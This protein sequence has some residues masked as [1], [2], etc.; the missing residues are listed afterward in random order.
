MLPE[1]TLMKKNQLLLSVLLFSVLSVLYSCEKNS[2]ED[3]PTTADRE[4]FL[5]TW[6]G[7]S[8]GTVNGQLNWNMVITASNSAPDQILMDNFDGVGN[9]VKIIASVSGNSITIPGAP[10]NVISAT[11]DTITGSGSY[12]SNN[13]LSFNFTV[14]DGQTTDFRTGSAH[15]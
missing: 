8:N 11:N 9:G 7:V 15:Q 2:T 1:N 5:G 12:N 6:Q 10:L 3:G 4:K 14:K 13:T